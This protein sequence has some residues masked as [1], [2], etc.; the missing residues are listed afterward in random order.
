MA[1]RSEAEG[2]SE[3]SPQKLKL[4]FFTP[5]FALFASLRSAILIGQKVGYF[6]RKNK[7]SPRQKKIDDFRHKTTIFKAQ[8]KSRPSCSNI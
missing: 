7:K 3:A 8:T 1:E 2:A 5:G 6:S 4:K